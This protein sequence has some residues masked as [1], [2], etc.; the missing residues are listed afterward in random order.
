MYLNIGDE[1]MVKDIEKEFEDFKKDVLLRL[2]E[3]LENVDSFPHDFNSYNLHDTIHE[4]V[5]SFVTG[6]TRKD[7]IA[8]IDFCDNEDYIDKGVVDESNIERM[9]ITTAFECIRQKLFDTEELFFDLQE[10]ELT[11]SKR[12]K[13]I[14][15]I[16]EITGKH[17]TTAKNHNESQIWITTNFDIEPEDF[18]EPFFAK[19]QIVDLHNGIKIMTHNAK[20]MKEIN[21][22]AIVLENTHKQPFRVYLMDKDKNIDIRD[23]FKFRSIKEGDYNLHPSFYVK[24]RNEP[25]KDGLYPFKTDFKEKKDLIFFLNRMMVELNQNN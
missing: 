15:R 1:K 7:S 2:K 13:F 4:E 10:Y 11:E 3:E 18:K 20:D 12:D 22:N 9:L 5:D 25:I 6:F 17:K 19:A 21:R 14:E 23:F 24:G 8:W 16:N